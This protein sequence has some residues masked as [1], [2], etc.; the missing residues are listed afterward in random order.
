MKL[1]LSVSPSFSMFALVAGVGIPL[2]LAT[3]LNAGLILPSPPC[4]SI[5]CMSHKAS[6]FTGE[7]IEAIGKPHV[8]IPH[9]IDELKTFFSR[10]SGS[11]QGLKSFYV[12]A[13]LLFDYVYFA[14]LVYTFAVGVIESVKHFSIS[15]YFS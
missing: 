14:L 12:L 2:W 4:Q 8:V 11:D 9:E 1:K 10:P 3:N 13:M 5:E 15:K 6:D 7:R